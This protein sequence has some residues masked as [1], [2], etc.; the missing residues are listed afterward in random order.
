MATLAEEIAF[1]TGDAGARRLG[2]VIDDLKAQVDDCCGGRGIA[3]AETRLANLNKNIEDAEK[4]LASVARAA[5]E[6]S[7]APTKPVTDPQTP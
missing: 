2:A 7:P 3:E 4:M 6:F 1:L 5:R